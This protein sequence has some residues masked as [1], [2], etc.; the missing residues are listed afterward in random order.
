MNRILFVTSEAHPVIK[1][2]GLADVS[3][4]L[5]QALKSLRQD[6]RIVMPAYADALPRLKQC[7]EIARIPLAGINQSVR[8]LESRLPKSSVIL[9]L[10]DAPG[11]FDRSGNPYVNGQG[12]DWPDNAQ[13]FALFC[14]VVS[15]IALGQAG[16]T[17][18]PDIVHCNDWQS[19]L[20]PA[21]LSLQDQRPATIFTIH[22]LAYQG[23]FP[24]E[25]FS[26]IHIPQSL[27]T[28]HGLE[29]FGQLSFIKGGIQFADMINTV[30]P[31]YAAEI[32]TA[33]F[34]YGLE[35]LLQHKQSQLVGILNGADYSQWNPARDTHL[36]YSYNS[37]QLDGKLQNKRWLQ[38]YCGLPVVDDTPLIGMIGRLVEQKG[39]D[40]V[41]AALPAL[42]RLGVQ[43]IILGSGQPVLQQAIKQA[44]KDYPQQIVI[45]M[46]Y[47]ETLAHQIEAS[48]DMFLMPS[49]YEPCGL[50]QIYSLR[51]GTLPIVRHT[52]GLANTVTDTDELSLKRK[53]AT[54]FVFEQAT[55]ADIIATV[56]RA[57][58]YYRQPKTW[59][60]LVYTAMQQDFSW[61][62]S[63]KHYLELYQQAIV[64][65]NAA[66]SRQT[67]A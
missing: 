36:K 65:K 47:D 62:R 50:N 3:G 14:R 25:T 1:T 26:E 38:H 67:T 2:G 17:W 13:R 6:I 24:A 56:E 21:L 40:L 5:P 18:Q 42:M 46:G 29:F 37:Y 51:Y 12:Q 58:S 11:L 32:C 31:Q 7:K 23:L 20:V 34:G 16:L 15:A 10:V 43:L 55:A 8:L 66:I 28:M 39:V 64:Q 59:K 4:S 49:R 61:R 9:W 19:G 54:G 35:G 52:G 60:K 22:N 48:A 45:H 33:E 30:S 57:L 41:L 53:T 63:A 44:H 27:W